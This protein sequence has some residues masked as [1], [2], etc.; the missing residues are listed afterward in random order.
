TPS[1][2]PMWETRISQQGCVK[3]HL[4]RLGQQVDGIHTAHQ[5]EGQSMCEMC[6]LRHREGREPQLSRDDRLIHVG[7]KASSIKITAD[8]CNAVLLPSDMEEMRGLTVEKLIKSSFRHTV[9]K[10]RE[11][12]QHI[13]RLE[14]FTRDKDKLL[15]DAIARV[16]EVKASKARLA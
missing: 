5:K 9:Q 1:F 3:E 14:A 12:F 8:L 11:F 13:G 7:D 6:F 15:A 2:V 10:N 4:A 16:E